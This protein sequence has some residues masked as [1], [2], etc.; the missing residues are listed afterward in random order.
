MTSASGKQGSTSN[1]GENT[2]YKGAVQATLVEIKDYQGRKT[3]YKGRNTGY[4]REN[5]DYK[6]KHGVYK[7][8]WETSGGTGLAS[9]FHRE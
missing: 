5:A 9:S 2:D 3:D 1:G 4:K 6:G 7:E 8:R